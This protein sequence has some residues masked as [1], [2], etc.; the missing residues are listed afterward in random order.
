MKSFLKKIIKKSKLIFLS[1]PSS[2]SDIYKKLIQEFNYYISTPINQEIKYNKINITT[3]ISEKYTIIIWGNSSNFSIDSFKYL[4]KYQDKINI[5]FLLTADLYTNKIKKILDDFNA[6]IFLF[7]KTVN[8]FYAI[9]IILNQITTEYCVF[10]SMLD[11][12]NPRSLITELDQIK[13]QKICFTFQQDYITNNNFKLSFTNISGIFFNLKKLKDIYNQKL[14]PKTSFGLSSFILHY[15]INDIEYINS[16]KKIF[17]IRYQDIISIQ[18]ISLLYKDILILKNYLPPHELI[19]LYQNTITYFLTTNCSI[20]Y[21]RFLIAV[22]AIIISFFENDFTQEEFE[23]IKANFSALFN[24]DFQPRHIEVQKT[25]LTLLKYIKKIEDNKISIIE[26]QYMEDLKNEFLPELAKHFSVRYITKPQYYDYHSFNCLVIRSQIEDSKFILSSNLL[27]NRM[28]KGKITISLWHGLGML[29]KVATIDPKKYLLDYVISSSKDCTN[30]WASAFNLPPEKILPLGNAHTDILYDHNFIT[31]NNNKIRKKYKINEKDKIVF[32][33]PT[34]RTSEN[35]KYYN[36]Q[37]DIE[38]LSYEL[39]KNNIY[40]IIKKHHVFQHE[41]NDRKI[42]SSNLIS[43]KN[44]YIIVDEEFTF[45]ELLTSANI[46]MTDYSSGIFYAT[47]L[48]LPLILYIPDYE[49]Y[50]IENGFYI[51][52]L[53]EIPASY[54]F[55]PDIT[56]LINI[57][58]TCENKISKSQYE[59]FKQIH[60]EACDGKSINRI[61]EWLQTI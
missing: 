37:I 52:Y 7:P 10:F 4:S 5:I 24:F 50:K 41:Y 1:K 23:T 38:E 56:E 13:N 3:P 33:A 47:L 25:L 16:S 14:L 15:F 18:D 6:T 54:I 43:S 45:N 30:I 55:S 36:F 17:I 57:F 19:T 60:V 39:E 51:D 21:K 40:L 34:F 61:I 12:I 58:L 29:K 59:L 31:E 22:T 20:Q 46:F 35:G 32:F 2:S 44:K 53:N 42:N 8:L 11:K 49:Q 26:T 27:D 28:K 9:Q 48:N